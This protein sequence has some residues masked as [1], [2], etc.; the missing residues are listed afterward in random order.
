M[1]LEPPGR[2]KA[3][4]FSFPSLSH[5]HIRGGTWERPDAAI[6]GEYLPALDGVAVEER[7]D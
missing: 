6:A 1:D 4:G 5:C 2:T 7:E 3:G